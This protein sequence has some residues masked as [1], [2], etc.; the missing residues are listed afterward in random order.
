MR[1]SLWMPMLSATIAVPLLSSGAVG[2]GANTARTRLAT[3]TRLAIVGLDHDHV[4]GILDDIAA[5]P[6]AEL[7]AV[8]DPH[9]E[10]VAKAKS[11]LPGTVKF[12]GDYVKM[13]DDA[14]P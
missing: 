7:V 14:K 13:L 8:A 1:K 6:Q 5:E 12:Y 11:H 2:Q 4:W 3:G 10:L 9:P